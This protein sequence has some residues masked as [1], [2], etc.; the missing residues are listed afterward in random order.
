[1]L[2]AGPDSGSPRGLPSVSPLRSAVRIG[3]NRIGRVAAPRGRRRAQAPQDSVPSLGS[4]PSPHS[5]RAGA[6]MVPLG[7]EGRREPGPRASR[8]EAEKDR[9]PSPPRPPLRR[10]PVPELREAQPGPDPA[11]RQRLLRA[12]HRRRSAARQGCPREGGRRATAST[13]AGSVRALPWRVQGRERS[14]AAVQGSALSDIG[15]VVRDAEALVE[16]FE[17]RETRTT[18]TRTTTCGGAAG[19]LG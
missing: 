1:M 6:G 9:A 8:L 10:R 16:S 3:V 18:E 13:R 4:V 5:G 15:Q 17:N 14:H 7:I 19:A 2:S 12:A 11:G